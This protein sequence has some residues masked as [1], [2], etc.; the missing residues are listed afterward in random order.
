MF[1]LLTENLLQGSIATDR[2]S[3]LSWKEEKPEKVRESVIR[4]AESDKEEEEGDSGEDD[5]DKVMLSVVTLFQI[6]ESKLQSFY[7][8]FYVSD[9]LYYFESHLLYRLFHVRKLSSCV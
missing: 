1:I 4:F 5:F 2:D 6:V 8:M 3:R 7:E 9:H